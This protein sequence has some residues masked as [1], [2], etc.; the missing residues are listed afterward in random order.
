MKSLAVLF[1]LATAL[2]SSSGVQAQNIFSVY[3]AADL[4]ITLGT[5]CINALANN[6]ACHPFVRTFVHLSYRSSLENVSLT[7]EVCSS[8]CYSSLKSWF[9]SVTNN[10]AGKAV[11]GAVANRLGGYMW[12]GV[13]ETCVKDPRTK[14]YCN[15][16]QNVSNLTRSNNSLYGLLL[17][18]CCIY[19]HNRQLHT[20][21]RLYPDATG[22][23]LSYLLHSASSHDAVVAVFHL[24]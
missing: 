5:G 16:E 8:D 13:N 15:G 2:N 23:A 11:S 24:R 14:N 21:V 9:D 20:S 19:R 22:R 10:C 4:D 3:N 18:H 6:V 1:C 7:N 12:A 17:M